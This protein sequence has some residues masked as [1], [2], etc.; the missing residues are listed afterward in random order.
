MI[1]LELY[2]RTVEAAIRAEHTEYLR[3]LKRV[4]LPETTTQTR[5]GRVKRKPIC[6]DDKLLKGYNAGIEQAIRI[7]SREFKAYEK[8]LEK[9]DKDGRRL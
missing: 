7:L 4:P 1:E 9:A 3:K 2:Y 8:R 5:R 6:I